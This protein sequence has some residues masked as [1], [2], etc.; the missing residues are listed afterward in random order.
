MRDEWIQDLV[1]PTIPSFSHVVI[2]TYTQSYTIKLLL[3]RGDNH[4]IIIIVIIIVIIIIMKDW[5]NSDYY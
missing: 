5:N 3:V 2:H 4:I 1:S